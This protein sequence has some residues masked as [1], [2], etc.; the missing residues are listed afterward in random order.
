MHSNIKKISIT[1]LVVILI[2]LLTITG[3]YAVII[4]VVE[5]DGVT[6]IVNIITIRDLLT[7]SSGNY[8]NTYYDVKNELDITSEEANLIM[9]N[10]SLN[11]G[12]QTVLNSIVEYNL[13]N[14]KDAKLTN[15]ELYNLIVE[16][17][18][19][20]NLNNELKDKIIS[21][22]NYYINDVSDYLYDT[23]VNLIG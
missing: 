23:P 3:T 12:L 18:N 2:F 22:S 10:S 8:N 16:K 17:T 19:N 20:S 1:L 7:D 13:H 11:E 6:E 9:D 5:K 4:D 21:K 15:L 14:N